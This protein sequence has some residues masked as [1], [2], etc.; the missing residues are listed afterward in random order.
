MLWPCVLFFYASV[1]VYVSVGHG[2]IFFIGQRY[3][4]NIF[5][6]YFYFVFNMD[7]FNCSNQQFYNI[8][9]ITESNV[10]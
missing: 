3:F 6:T 8:F 2:I 7:F 10:A 4:S 1:C 9:E 5:D